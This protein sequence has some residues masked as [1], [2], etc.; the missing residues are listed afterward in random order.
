MALELSSFLAQA[1][2]TLDVAVYDLKLGPAAFQILQS[3][4]AAA[5]DR[6]VAI[7]IAYNVDHGKRAP[8]P[9]PPKTHPV[10]V[11]SLAG[12]ARAIPGVPDL[13]HHKYVVRDGTTVWSGSTNWTDDSWTRQENVVVVLESPAVAAAF[14]DDFEQLWTRLDVS[15]TGR[16]PPDPVS[17]SGVEV[18]PWFCPG[19]GERLAHRIAH[20]IGHASRVVRIA[21]P[22]ITSGPILGTL[23]E[24]ASD[25]RLDLAGVVDLTQVREVLH[26]WR[27][28]GN[29]TWKAPALLRSLD[30]G[31]FSGKP[32][33]P[34]S[35]TS[36][37]DFMHAKLTIADDTLFVG[38]FNLSHSGEFNAENVVEIH[39]AR[40][41]AEAAAFVDAIRVRYPTVE[42]RA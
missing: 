22:V 26:Q 23:A 15:R 28:N 18:R 40:L 10:L 38:S 39:D 27:A 16:V 41:A 7:R 5:H 14:A 30:G 31:R 19:R 33:T 32:S 25:G 36:I 3:T 11:E 1:Q 12:E 21:S 13:M 17:V 2:R 9:P 24:L 29:A 20:V 34:W 35:P 6:G 4:L 37:H 8:V 42:L